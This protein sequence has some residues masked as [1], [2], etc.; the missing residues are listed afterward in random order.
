MDA[1]KARELKTQDPLAICKLVIVYMIM[2][3]QRAVDIKNALHPHLEKTTQWAMAKVKSISKIILEHPIFSKLAAS[4]PESLYLLV[5]IGLMF[6][7]IFW[8]ITLSLRSSP[9]LEI[10][11]QRFA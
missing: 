7:K 1:S 10:E 11:M 4:K 5:I 8:D 6:V 9:K 2:L 3:K